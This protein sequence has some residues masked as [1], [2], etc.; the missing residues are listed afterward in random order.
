MS[1]ARTTP[2]LEEIRRDIDAVDAQLLALLERRFEAIDRIRAA[3]ASAGEDGGSPMRPGREAV[4][5]RRLESLRR[6]HLPQALMVRL[7]RSIMSAATAAQ[8]NTTVYLS[9]AVMADPGLVALCTGSVSGPQPQGRRR[10]CCRCSRRGQRYRYRRRAA[11]RGVDR[12]S[13]LR[14]LRR[15]EGDGLF[16]AARPEEQSSRSPDL[17]PCP[18]GNNRRRPDDRDIAERR[19][20]A[21]GL[22]LRCGRSGAATSPLSVWRAISPPKCRTS[23]AFPFASPG[24]IQA[25]S[26]P[27]SDHAG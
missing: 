14:L 24:I 15:C 6:G 25:R 1:R 23:P 13:R 17:R 8:A 11:R 12:K 7:W 18:P 2:S 5:L 21:V 4:I 22:A 26:K 27:G 9:P 20:P 19:Q 16:A 3:K 10:S